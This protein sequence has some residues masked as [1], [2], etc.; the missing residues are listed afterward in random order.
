MAKK[1]KKL[2]DSE[3]SMFDGPAVLTLA[4]G[5]VLTVLLSD[6]EVTQDQLDVTTFSDASPK[7]MLGNSRVRLDGYI[8]QHV[9]GAP[10]EFTPE[11]KKAA[12]VVRR[13]ISLEDL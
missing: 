5:T 11:T 10:P 12:E 9:V 8:L 7:Y 3:K 4:D 6:I 13:S 2:G 1:A